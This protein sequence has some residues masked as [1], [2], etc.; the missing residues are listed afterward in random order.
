M[1]GGFAPRRASVLFRLADLLERHA[2]EAAE[3][4]ALDNGTPVSVM[5]PGFYTAA[6]IRYYAGWCDKLDGEMM[7]GE[8]GLTYVRLEPYGVIAVIPPW[9]G[10][11]MGMGQKCGPA[12]AAGNTIVANRRRYPRSGCSDSPSWRWK[13]DY[14]RGY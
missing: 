2:T 13:P 14:L 1:G 10:S 9:N 5:N 6:W 4:A 3:L 12:L 11:M 8:P 7:S